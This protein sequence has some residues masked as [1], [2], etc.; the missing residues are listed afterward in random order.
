MVLF[1][2]TNIHSHP[3]P[4]LKMDFEFSGFGCKCMILRGTFSRNICKKILF[5]KIKRTKKIDMIYKNK[6]IESNNQIG[7]LRNE[8]VHL[9]SIVN[10]DEQKFK[11]LEKYVLKH[12]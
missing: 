1:K 3:E 2:T 7:I 9:Q 10:S 6:Y 5:L 8:V 11:E 4:A 12:K